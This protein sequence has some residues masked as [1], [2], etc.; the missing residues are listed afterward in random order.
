MTDLTHSNSLTDLAVRIRDEHAKVKEAVQRG[1][2]HAL[3]AGRLLWDAKRRVRH[4]GWMDW[5]A[6]NCDISQSTAN[7]YMNVASK[8]PGVG[9]NSQCI[10][11]MTLNEAIALISG[12]DDEPRPTGGRGRGTGSKNALAEAVKN[13]PLS[14]IESAWP[15]LSPALPR[16]SATRSPIGRD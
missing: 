7:L 6:E 10:T 4:G 8:L 14:V 1:A 9:S 16:R 11:N 12:R 15:N 13:K 3:E 5:V 2:E